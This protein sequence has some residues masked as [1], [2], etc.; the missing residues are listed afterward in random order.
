MSVVKE[1]DTVSLHYKGWLDDGT[2]FDS[3]EG[4]QPLSF[5]V[6]AGQVIPGFDDAVR[7]MAAGENRQINIPADQAY[8]PY[9]DDLVRVVPRSAFPAHTTPTIGFA[10][11][12]EL[13]SGEPMTV[14][15]ID[16]EGD[17]ITLDANHLLAGENLH[18]DVHLVSIDSE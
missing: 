18:F 13:P 15:I 14:R 6:G 4:R 5:R 2:V 16:I 8:G 11:D 3:S 10:F 9:Y 17:E 1:G 7:G 12:M